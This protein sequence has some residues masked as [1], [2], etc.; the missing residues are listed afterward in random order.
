MSRLFWAH[1]E[2]ALL[3]SSNPNMSLNSLNGLKVDFVNTMVK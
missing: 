1:V 3:G 2:F